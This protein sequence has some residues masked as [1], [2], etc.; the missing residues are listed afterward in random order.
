MDV[1]NTAGEATE[2]LGKVEHFAQMF[3][4][5]FEGVLAGVQCQT[6]CE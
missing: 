6:E 1:V 4:L 3:E 5:S 2:H